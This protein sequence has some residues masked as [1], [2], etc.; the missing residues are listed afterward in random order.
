MLVVG[1]VGGGLTICQAHWYT[2]H[3][4]GLQAV[5]EGLLTW[6]ACAGCCLTQAQPPNAWEAINSD[7]ACKFHK[8]GHP[9]KLAKEVQAMRQ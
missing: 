7:E 3:S 1:I 2:C 9:Q 4:S 8:H 6:M 5:E